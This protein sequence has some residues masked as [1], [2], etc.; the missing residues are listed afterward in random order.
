[1]S[2][3][4]DKFDV[5]RR[6]IPVDYR[7]DVY[8]RFFSKEYIEYISSSITL[9]LDSLHPEGKNIIVPNKTIL[10]VM[11]SIYQNTYRDVDKMTMMTIEY[12]AD[13]IR[14]E[15]EIESQN[16]KLS[17]WVINFLPE[18][19]IQQTPKIKL[20]EKRPTTGIFNMNY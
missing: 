20:R 18:Y 7:Q 19:K 14:N 13:Y 2:Y 10:S 16:K 4:I 5:E 15:Y 17:K 11:D 9:K 6:P 1:M 3:Y 8:Y 12:I